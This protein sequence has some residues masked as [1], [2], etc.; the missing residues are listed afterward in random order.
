MSFNQKIVTLIDHTTA[1]WN[2]ENI[3]VFQNI[4]EDDIIASIAPISIGTTL[5]EATRIEGK[6]KLIEYLEK[7]KGKLPLRYEAE[8][9]INLINKRISYSKHFYQ[10]GIRAHVT[11]VFSEYGKYKEFHIT[12]YENVYDKKLNLFQILKNAIRYKLSKLFSRKR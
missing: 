6:D 1:A 7:L 3:E 8:Y 9:D 12:S 2:A 10:I 5:I 11:C 4:L